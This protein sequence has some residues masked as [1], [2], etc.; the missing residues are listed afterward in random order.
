MNQNL[1]SLPPELRDILA[2]LQVEAVAYLDEDFRVLARPEV[3]HFSRT[4]R[5]GETLFLR[6][7]AN[8]DGELGI[9]DAITTLR[10]LFLRADAPQCL[11]AADTNDDGRLNLTDPTRALLHLFGGRALPL[12]YPQCGEDPTPDALN[13]ERVAACE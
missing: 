3:T 9:A 5:Q 7:D 2:N 10:Y 11:K 1:Q 6:G 4:E 12:P 13:C 8:S